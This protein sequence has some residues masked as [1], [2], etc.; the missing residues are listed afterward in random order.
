MKKILFLV[1][2]FVLISTVGYSQEKPHTSKATYYHSKFNGRKTATGDIYS[3]KLLT[4][5]SNVY[6]LGTKLLVTNKR[7][8]KSVQV[9]VNDRMAPQIKG[10]VDL[11]RSAFQQ[12][13]NLGTGIIPVEIEILN[14]R[15]SEVM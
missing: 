11:S 13:A 15:K 12:I 4:A 1:F 3:D 6:K 10:R 14:G 5:A 7:T 8:G 9:V 2:T